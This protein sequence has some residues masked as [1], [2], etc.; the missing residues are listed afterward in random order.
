V[1]WTVRRQLRRRTSCATS[2]KRLAGGI[3]TRRRLCGVD[4]VIFAANARTCADIRS[5]APEP[6]AH[7]PSAVVLSL[8]PTPD[9]VPSDPLVRA[10]YSR[11]DASDRT[12]A[13]GAC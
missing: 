3:Q 7:A 6:A 12:T 8:S 10:G 11:V 1:R 4:A 13:D 2:K 9:P 5:A